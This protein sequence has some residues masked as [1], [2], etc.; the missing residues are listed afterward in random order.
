MALMGLRVQRGPCSKWAGEEEAEEG[1]DKD[2]W[3]KPSF[4]LLLMPPETTPSPRPHTAGRGAALPS[5]FQGE[6]D[7]LSGIVEFCISSSSICTARIFSMT[8]PSKS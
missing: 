6:T 5:Y 7:A 2:T 3:P 4:P 1:Q 8:R